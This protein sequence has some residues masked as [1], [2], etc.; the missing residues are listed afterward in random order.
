MVS[1]FGG[2][3]C[4]ISVT[5]IFHTLK[6]KLNVNS[7]GKN[8]KNPLNQEDCFILEFLWHWTLRMS[9]H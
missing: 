8:K 6:P 1:I 9:L 2:K 4:H 3:I 5:F 7:L